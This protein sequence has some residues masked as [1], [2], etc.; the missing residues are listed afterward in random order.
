MSFPLLHARGQD[1][2]DNSPNCSTQIKD[3]FLRKSTIL[4]KMAF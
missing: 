3:T 2:L 4:R 1:K